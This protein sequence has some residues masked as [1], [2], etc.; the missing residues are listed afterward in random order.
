MEVKTSRGDFA[1]VI[2]FSVIGH[3]NWCS[4][5]YYLDVVIEILT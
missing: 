5:R 3:A 4:E 1:S 2:F